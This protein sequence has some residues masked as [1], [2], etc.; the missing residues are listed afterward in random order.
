[1]A[2]N[3]F[4]PRK[5]EDFVIQDENSQVVGHIRVKPNGVLW[6]PKGEHN[7]YGLTLNQFSKFA[8]ESGKKQKK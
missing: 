7:W 8:T 6:C 5:Y 2:K 3:E 4:R 1:M